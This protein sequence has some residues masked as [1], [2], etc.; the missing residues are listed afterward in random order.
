[1]SMYM[2]I[3]KY[4]RRDIATDMGLDRDV[5]MGKVYYMSML[6]SVSMAMLIFLSMFTS[7]PWLCG[8]FMFMVMFTS[9]CFHAERHFQ[10][11]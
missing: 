9:E 3:G 5:N 10:D 8:M 1:M 2:N 6:M 7:G 4:M 11:A